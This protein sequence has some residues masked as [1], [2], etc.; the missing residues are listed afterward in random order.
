MKKALLLFLFAIGASQIAKAANGDTTYVVSHNQ[1]VVVTNPGS[2]SNPYPAWA[3]FPS[4]STTYRKVILNMYYKCPNGQACGEWD[5]L[6]YVYIRRM[7]GVNDTS[8]DMEI[9]RYI[10]PYGNSFGQTWHAE[11]YIDI[12][13]YAMLLHDS[14]EIE[15]IHTGYETN[16][17]KGWEVTLEFALIEGTPAMEPVKISQLWNGNFL[18]G[19][20]ANPIE[21]NLMPI[22]LT[23]DPATELMRVRM[24]QTGHGADATNCAE[25]C[26]K[27]R[28]FKFD[29][30]TAFTKNVFKLCGKNPLYPQAGTWVYNRSN[31]C[32]GELVYP[33]IYDFPVA[34]SSMHTV[35]VDMTPYTISN[36]SARYRFG[37]QAI[38]YKL[39]TLTDDAGLEEIY[40]PSNHFH[41]SR[42]NPVCD[43]ASVKMR[44][45]GSGALTSAVIRYGL[46]GSTLY[47]YNWAGNL[48]A[49]QAVTLDLDGYIFPA[50]G[51]QTFR[52]YIES[53][54]GVTDQYPHDDT[55][56]ATALIPQVLDTTFVFNIK[57]NNIP[58]QTYY[59]FY[60]HNNVIVH[61]TFPGTLTANTTYK[62]TLTFAPGCYR[63]VLFDSGNDG[64]S[65]WANP[66][67]GSG[68]ARFLNLS[69][70]PTKVFNPDFGAEVEFR[71]Q[72]D[73]N[74][75][76]SAA[77]PDRPESRAHIYPNP[78]TGQVIV[79]VSIPGSEKVNV[80]VFDLAGRQVYSGT[81]DVVV[82]EL[83]ALDLSGLQN[84][85]YHVHVT[86]GSMDVARKV[87]LMR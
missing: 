4:T 60:N 38:E 16:V 48:S 28:T 86:S 32:P 64:L 57:T 14:V 78:T 46:T 24:L 31:W 13:D 22:S 21:N 87:V 26:Q 51:N 84:G 56:Y 12:T 59:R 50:P 18:Y 66:N 40:R 8:L 63:L 1:Q 35:D 77:T 7:G 25:F 41:D 33:D 15:Y 76:V 70:A 54:N 34:G 80:E 53:V 27:G 45:N 17:G 23:M 49:N 6:D 47:S 62:D 44:N 3:V 11:F 43:H 75:I 83:I 85:I 30:N 39:P 74:N 61:Q 79:D 19:S 52:A 20:A 81:H 69:G 29:G 68:Y 65:W 37:S 72:V 36:P 55:I 71:F 9:V 82:N 5:Y 67:Q 10:T 73:P 58:T 2:G 42:E